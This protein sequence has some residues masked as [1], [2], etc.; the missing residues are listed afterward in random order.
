M[1]T[2]GLMAP[3]GNFESLQSAIDN[4]ADSTYFRVEQFNMSVRASINFNLNDLPEIVR[5]CKPEIYAPK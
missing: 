1:D 5:R 4:G 2:I 3:A